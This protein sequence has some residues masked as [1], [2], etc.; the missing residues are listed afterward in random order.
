MSCRQ[1]G[2]SVQFDRIDNDRKNEELYNKNNDNETDYINT[3]RTIP[4][5]VGL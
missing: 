3:F 5:Y 1:C 2:E 4:Y